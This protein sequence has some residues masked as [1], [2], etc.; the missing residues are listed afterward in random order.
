MSNSQSWGSRAGLILA[1]AGN[2][3]GLGNFLRFPVQAVE[4]GGGAFLIP[5]LTCFLLM[6]IPLLWVEWSM[7]RLGGSHGYH[8]TPFMFQAIG[9]RKFWAY[10]GVFGIFTNIGVAS[11]YCYI[12]SWTLSYAIHSVKG[13]F[14]GLSQEETM[15]FFDR[16]IHFDVKMMGIPEAILLFVV[17][18]FINSFIL[19]KGLKGI[20]TVAKIGMPL[21]ILF[22]IFLSIKALTL[23]ASA[24]SAEFPMANAWDGLNYLWTPQYDTIWRPKI[25]LAAAGQIFFT[26]SVGMGTIHCFAAYLKERDDVALNA[27][28]A[29]FTNEFIEVILGSLIVVPIA[30]GYLGLDWIKAHIGFGVAFQTMPYLFQ[31]WG[32]FLAPLA[33]VLWFGLLFFAGITSSLAM[34]TPWIGFMRDE[35]SWSQNKSAYSFGLLTLLFGLPCVLF[36][37]KGVFDEYDYWAGT[38]SLVIFALMEIILFAW[39]YGID[40]GWAEI[41]RGADITVPFFYKWIIKYITPLLLLLVFVGAIFTPENSNWIDGF[42]TLLKGGGWKL[43][44]G[45]LIGQLLSSGIREQIANTTDETQL[46][47]L[48]EKMWYSYGARFMLSALFIGICL[49]VYKASKNH[50]S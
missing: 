49:L 12:E 36:Y 50:K 21:L 37:E 26:L 7:G 40:K 35:Y 18:V 25:W 17:C 8:A 13:T 14:Q 42:D 32:A 16:F 9:K 27:V 3:V 30:A 45:S 46:A 28:S 24:S 39:V 10:I 33:G 2:S 41:N 44:H 5:Y 6:G 23:G 38:V 47:L 22:G 15:T 48:R 1:M 43:D 34:G 31:Q 29:G 20:E 11:Y 19:S 4:N